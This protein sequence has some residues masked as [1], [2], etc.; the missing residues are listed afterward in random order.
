ME[1]L[2]EQ[3]HALRV[4][5]QLPIYSLVTPKQVLGNDLL[6]S[7]LYLDKKSDRRT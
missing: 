5:A 6:P 4:L 7:A 3:L 2:Q 1:I